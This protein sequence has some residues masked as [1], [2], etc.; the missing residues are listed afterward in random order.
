MGNIVIRAIQGPN[1]AA[2]VSLIGTG[3]RVNATAAT[4][5]TAEAAVPAAA[6]GNYC[7]V[8]TQGP[9]AIRFGATGVGAAAA[10]NTS[11]FLPAG[12]HIFKLAAT[13]TH[14]RVIR[15]I[16]TDALLQLESLTS[17]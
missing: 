14:F 17:Q 5:S 12:E 11:T 15:S 7:R 4:A 1:G 3:T 9:I 16:A 2:P 10:D 13:D 6:A 8:L